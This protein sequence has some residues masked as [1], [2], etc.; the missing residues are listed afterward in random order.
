MGK[1]RRAV[2]V[3]TADDPMFGRKAWSARYDSL[4]R[5]ASRPIHED[6]TVA[7]PWAKRLRKRDR[8]H[9]RW[10]SDGTATWSWRSRLLTQHN[11][12]EEEGA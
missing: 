7:P 11:A 12:E 8:N 3:T 5:M 6:M 1:R 9:S 2:Y 10:N 4:D